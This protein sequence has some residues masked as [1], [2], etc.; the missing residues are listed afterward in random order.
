M[1][2][3]LTL[4]AAVTVRGKG[5]GPSSADL[6]AAGS[7]CMQHLDLVGSSG[8]TWGSSS[9]LPAEGPWGAWGFVLLSQKGACTVEQ[10][11]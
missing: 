5:P 6:A 10:L 9:P 4:T 2:S 3:A 7:R 1:F 11:G 8:C